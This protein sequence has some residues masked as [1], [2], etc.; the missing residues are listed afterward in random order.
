MAAVE[1]AASGDGRSHSRPT[2]ADGTLPALRFLTAGSVDDGKSTLIGR[3][4]YDSRAI[5]ADQ[6]DALRARGSNAAGAGE[7]TTPDLSLLAYVG[8]R[9]HE[10]PAV[11]EKVRALLGLGNP[12][13]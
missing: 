9:R 11:A 3:L 8:N 2:R 4:L 1:N 7:D 6:L 10:L 13:G 5:L 12:N